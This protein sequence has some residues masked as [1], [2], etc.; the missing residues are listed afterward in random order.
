MA[1]RSFLLAVLCLILPAVAVRAAEDPVLAAAT[2]LPGFVM[3]H[4]SGAPGLILVV[5]R[6]DQTLLR[7]YGET[8]K[9][10]KR[11]PDGA[12]LL[13]LNSVTKVFTTEVLASLAAERKL[14]LTD[15]LQRFAGDAKA[16]LFGARPITLLDLATHSI[17]PRAPTP[18][19]GRR[20][21]IAG[22]GCP[23]T[24]CPGR[25]ARSPPIR[26]SALIFW[27]TRSRPRAA[28]PIPTS[29]ANTSP[30]RLA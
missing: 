1:M 28:R 19:R 2:E 24:R 23:A 15:P 30:R 12:S 16:P 29:C 10:N 7:G 18:A 6:G 17:F 20:A 21:P 13:R 5:V 11:T 22:N 9:G 8:E 26:M 3:F 4:E 27:P 25:R 14:A